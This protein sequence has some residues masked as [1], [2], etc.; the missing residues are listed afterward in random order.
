VGLLGRRQP[1]KVLADRSAWPA[2]NRI[3]SSSVA[4]GHRASTVRSPRRPTTAASAIHPQAVRRWEHW[5]CPVSAA[6]IRRRSAADENLAHAMQQ[7]V[8]VQTLDVAEV[9]HMALGA[10]DAREDLLAGQSLFSVAVSLG[11]FSTGGGSEA[12]NAES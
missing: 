10:A 4:A 3:A 1:G 6:A 11:S 5:G 9:G 12:Q 8:A 2:C 7:Q